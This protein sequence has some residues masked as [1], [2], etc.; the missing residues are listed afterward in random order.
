MAGNTTE[1]IWINQNKHNC[2]QGGQRKNRRKPNNFFSK[3]K[4][5]TKSNTHNDTT[6]TIFKPKTPKIRNPIL[7]YMNCWTCILHTLLS[8]GLCENYHT[9]VI[10]SRA[11]PPHVSTTNFICWINK[12]IYIH[13]KCTHNIYMNGQMDHVSGKWIILLVNVYSVWS[14]YMHGMACCVWYV[15]MARST[16]CACALYWKN[17]VSHYFAASQ[18]ERTR[19]RRKKTEIAR[20]NS[21]SLT[22]HGCAATLVVG[23]GEV[24]A[25]LLRPFIAYARVFAYTKCMAAMRLLWPGMNCMPCIASVRYQCISYQI[26]KNNWNILLFENHIWCL[27]WEKPQSRCGMCCCLLLAAYTPP[28]QSEIGVSSS[29]DNVGIIAHHAMA[30]AGDWQQMLCIDRYH[31]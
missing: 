25:Q 29:S 30:I 14:W 21:P 22:S 6:I 19:N 15:L 8:I 23:C 24:G 28:A 18:T 12:E 3:W 10:L 4:Q 17:I 2:L 27:H 20:G 11:T 16:V 13:C 9:H 7:C 5:Y 1:W 26:P 31:E